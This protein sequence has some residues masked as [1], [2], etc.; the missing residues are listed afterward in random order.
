MATSARRRL[1]STDVLEIL[2]SGARARRVRA[3]PVRQ[4]LRVRRHCGSRVN[5][6]RGGRD[7]VHRARQPMGER[8]SGE[9]RSKAGLCAAVAQE[10][11]ARAWAEPVCCGLLRVKLRFCGT[12]ATGR[13]GLQDV[14]R[15]TPQLVRKPAAG[16]APPSSNKKGGRHRLGSVVLRSQARRVRLLLRPAYL[17]SDE[18]RPASCRSS[19]TLP[20]GAQGPGCPAAPRS[21]RRRRRVRR[22]AHGRVPGRRTRPR[23]GAPQDPVVARPSGSSGA[24]P[25]LRRRR[26][27]SRRRSA[28]WSCSSTISMPSSASI[29]SSIVTSPAVPP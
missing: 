19:P 20:L 13:A 8:H 16:K 17:P 26:S 3:H 9:L 1:S 12:S 2:Q 14:A 5:R 23:R 28:T 21:A 6:R 7:G 24:P 29:R 25:R 22:V 27:A 15:I 11:D 18:A 10:T 4:W